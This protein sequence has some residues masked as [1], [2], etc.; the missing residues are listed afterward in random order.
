[1]KRR[2]VGG[3]GARSSGRPRVAEVR[4]RDRNEEGLAG[5]GEPRKG[6]WEE[7][8]GRQ[9]LS[10]AA[11]ANSLG[12]FSSLSLLASPVQESGMPSLGL[13]MFFSAAVA[14]LRLNTVKPGLEFGFCGLKRRAGLSQPSSCFSVWGWMLEAKAVPPHLSRPQIV[15][16]Q[17]GTTP[18]LATVPTGSQ[19]GA[20]VK[21]CALAYPSVASCAGPTGPGRG[22]QREGQRGVALAAEGLSGP[23]V[24]CVRASMGTG[25]H[26]LKGRWGLPA[27]WEHMGESPCR[28]H[29]VAPRCCVRFR[30]ASAPLPTGSGEGRGRCW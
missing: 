24:V 18:G 6:T 5:E 25:A 14:G 1:M 23:G 7:V 12:P 17:A 29:T 3:S 10:W 20:W 11:T 22:G 2:V 21:R 4:C 16:E 26:I 19:Q 15:M 8:L 30:P 9:P 13:E 28:G 27:G